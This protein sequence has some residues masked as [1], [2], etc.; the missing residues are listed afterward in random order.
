MTAFSR[1]SRF[2]STVNERVLP[3]WK[4]VLVQL[5]RS[6]RWLRRRRRPVALIIVGCVLLYLGLPYGRAGPSV[7]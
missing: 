6:R 4:S 2:V 1:L 5:E 3:I 7:A